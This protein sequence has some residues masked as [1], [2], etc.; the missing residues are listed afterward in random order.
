[1]TA[2]TVKSSQVSGFDSVPVTLEPGSKSGNANRVYVATYEVATT[3]LDEAA[4]IIKMI[5]IPSKLRITS[6]TLFNDDLDSHATPTLAVDIGLY[7]SKTGSALDADC[8]SDSSANSDTTLQA[9]NK[10]GVE[11]LT[12][13]SDIANIGKQAWEHASGITEDP[14]VPLDIAITVSTEAATA[15]AGTIT[16]RVIGSLD[17]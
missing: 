1:M 7:N 9:A 14:K 16:M 15:A 12:K 4:D 3:S 5:R 6:I 10:A 2:S 8:F 11:M 17:S 13:T